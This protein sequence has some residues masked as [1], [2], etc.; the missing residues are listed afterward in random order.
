M[1]V[2]IASTAIAIAGNLW[3]WRQTD[4]ADVDDLS[5][6]IKELGDKSTQ[7]LLFLSFAIVGAATWHTE[8]NERPLASAMR[9]WIAAVFPVL[10]GVVPLREVFWKSRNWY[11]LIVCVKFT[12]LCIAVVVALW[13]RRALST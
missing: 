4:L 8:S 9:W 12:L 3:L 7:L 2:T 13:A 11:R 1:T 6:R 5:E 10:A